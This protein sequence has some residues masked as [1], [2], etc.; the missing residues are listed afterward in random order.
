MS[1]VESFGITFVE[2]MACRL[3]VVSFNSKGANEIIVNQYN[4]YI[5]NSESIDDFVKKIEYLYKNKDKINFIKINTY[6][7][8]KYDLDFK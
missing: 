4:G 5:I 1:R 8:E 3:P 2:A 6:M 7:S